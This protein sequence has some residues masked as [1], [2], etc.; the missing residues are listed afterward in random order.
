MAL[1]DIGANLADD[2]FDKDRAEV[3]ERAHQAG[4]TR[5]VITGSD[6]QS[7]QQAIEMARQYPGQCYAT[8]GLHPHHA[9]DWNQQLAADI[10]QAAANEQIVAAGEAGLDYF[11]DISPRDQQRQ[12][13]MQQ[14]EIAVR[15]QLPVFLHQRAAHEDFLA[16]LRDY[17]PHLKR[18]VVHCFTGDRDMLADYLELD[19]YIGITGWICDARRGQ[20]LFEAAEIIPDR[21]LLIETDSPYLMP[22]TIRP[23]PKTRRNEPVWLPWIRDH[24]ALARQTSP[25]HIE[26]ITFDNACRFFNLD[27]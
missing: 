10:E 11:R 5:L 23:R 3:I 15:H 4:V 7:N 8:A 18:A 20:D 9:Q 21:R 26:Q 12:A 1:I 25:E 14:L 13:F 27:T 19:V 6:A 16:I 2:S 24:V 17:L 22:R